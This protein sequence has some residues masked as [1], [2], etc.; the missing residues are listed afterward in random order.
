MRLL[1]QNPTNGSM[2]VQIET[3]DDIWHLF[4]VLESGD[5]I[6]SVTMRRDEKATD[7]LRAER[8]EKK[9]MVLSVKVEKIEFS[10]SDLR[11]RVLGTITDGPQ[12]IGQYHTLIFEIG[13]TLTITKEKWK[14]TQVERLRKAVFES[15]RPKVVFVSLDQDEASI[16]VLRQFGLKE[17]ATIRSM[18]SGKQYQEKDTPSGYH[19]EIISK[20]AAVAEGDMPLVLLGPG[21]EKELLA[22]SGKKARPDIFAKAHVHHTGQSGMPG[23]NELMK[24]GMGANILR[25]SRV[26]IEMEAVE[27]LMEEIGREGAATYGPKHTEDAAKAGAVETLLILDSL[28]RESDH[29]SVVKDTESQKGNVIIVSERHDAG[30]QLASLGGIAA[31]LRYRMSG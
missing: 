30:R 6:T 18:R 17:I 22:E 1:D 11:L 10:D 15:K 28:I 16:A 21:F 4:N 27:K 19:D 2:R 23:I 25:E 31:I 29:E 20:V 3:E 8:A 24:K 14:D 7:K 13:E 5:V 9:R 26:A 12:D